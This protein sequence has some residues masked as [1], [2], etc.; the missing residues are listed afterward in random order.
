MRNK[1]FQGRQN[2]VCPRGI[3]KNTTGGHKPAWL[4]HI[5]S[6]A[7]SDGPTVTCGMALPNPVDFIVLPNLLQRFL[8]DVTQ[9]QPTIYILTAGN[10][11]TITNIIDAIM[12]VAMIGV[13]VTA[14]T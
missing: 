8:L 4:V 11:S 14:F 9:C 2:G 13:C 10:H 6:M 1:G 5:T 7:D 12:D 3:Q